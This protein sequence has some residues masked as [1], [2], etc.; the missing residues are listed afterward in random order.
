[1]FQWYEA[2]CG[3]LA[4]ALV[5]LMFKVIETEKDYSEFLFWA[6]NVTAEYKSCVLYTSLFSKVYCVNGPDKIVIRYITKGHTHL[7]Y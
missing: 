3:R 5:D 2:L 7:R 1:M 6:D 4:E